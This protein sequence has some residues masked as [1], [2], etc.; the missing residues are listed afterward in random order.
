M[1]SEVSSCRVLQAA[2]LLLGVGRQTGMKPG[3]GGRARLGCAGRS[4][5]RG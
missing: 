2:V 3:A 5:R 4:G 1:G